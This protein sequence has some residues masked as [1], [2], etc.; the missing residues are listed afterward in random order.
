MVRHF[1]TVKW[2][3]LHLK[4][5]LFRFEV[6]IRRVCSLAIAGAGRILANT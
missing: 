4:E 2:L 5:K 6:E 1:R 3:Q